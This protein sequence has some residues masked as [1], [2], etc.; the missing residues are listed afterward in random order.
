MAA[1]WANG[2]SVNAHTRPV[3]AMTTVTLE[4][5]IGLPKL[6]VEG[7]ENHYICQKEVPQPQREANATLAN[8]KRLM[9]SS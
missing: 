1:A 5:R 9:E 4:V 2:G 7:K 8:L 3:I 6:L